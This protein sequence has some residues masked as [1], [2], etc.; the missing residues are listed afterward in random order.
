[1]IHRHESKL[2]IGGRVHDRDIQ[3]IPFGDRLPIVQRSPAQRIH[4]NLKA[5]FRNRLH[6]DDVAQLF[7]VRRQ[8]IAL[9]GSRR[10]ERF[11]VRNGIH[12]GIIRLKQFIRPP[13]HRARDI[14]IGRT[15]LRRVVLKTA[16]GWR[17]MA[18]R[19][20]DAIGQIFRFS[21]VPGQNRQRNG[22]SWCKTVV[23]LDHRP[24][25]IRRQNPKRGLLRRRRQRVRIHPHQHWSG[26]AHFRPVLTDRLGD[27]QN[28]SLVEGPRRGSPAVTT[29]TEADC[30][31]GI[32][33]VRRQLVIGA[34]QSRHVNQQRSGRAVPG[35]G[36]KGWFQTNSLLHSLLRLRESK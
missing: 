25:F 31:A 36:V 15:T 23:L 14:G 12:P 6:V 27:G 16:I 18:W 26:D 22:R 21:P 11:L 30:L 4:A 20:D 35:E 3:A 33:R 13:L 32:V 34:I 29:G 2:R 24:N 8:E 19:D 17:I 7:H 28:M 10:R 5:G 1:M 9:L